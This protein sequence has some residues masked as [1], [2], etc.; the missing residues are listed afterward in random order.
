MARVLGIVG[1]MRKNQHTNVLVSTL[2]KDI[3][4]KISS[5]DSEIIHICKQ[6]IK[7]CRVT[8]SDFCRQRNYECIIDDD[9]SKI[10]NLMKQADMIILG[11]PLY[12]RAP[13]AR[14]HTFIERLVA[15]FFYNETSGQKPEVSPLINKPCGLI[16]LAEYSNP[17]QILEYLSDFCTQAKMNPVRIKKFPYLGIAGQGNIHQDQIFLPFERSKD[18]ATAMVSCLGL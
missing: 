14:L 3:K 5:L 12:F 2:I 11:A 13:P 4:E 15:L 7:P 1:S 18:L 16:A 10:L 17:H 8:C 6:E 9:V